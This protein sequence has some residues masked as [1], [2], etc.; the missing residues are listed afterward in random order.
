MCA[1]FL[2]TFSVVTDW[3]LFTSLVN[4]K[5]NGVSAGLD[6]LGNEVYI[7]RGTVNGYLTPGRIIVETVGNKIGRAHV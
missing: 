1:N 7:G 4:V 3:K 2:N 5:A 6:S